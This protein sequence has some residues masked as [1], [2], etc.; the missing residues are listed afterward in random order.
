VA[1]KGHLGISDNNL[2]FNWN[3]D[4]AYRGFGNPPQ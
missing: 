4:I 3:V 2:G 1:Y